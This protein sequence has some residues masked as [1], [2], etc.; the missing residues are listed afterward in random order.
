MIFLISVVAE[1]DGVDD[2]GLFYTSVAPLSTITM[3]SLVAD[4]G[5]VD[6]A[7]AALGVGRVDDE[8]AVDLT[9]AH[10]ADGAVERNVR[11]R[12]RCAGGV[13]ADDVGIVFLVSGEDQ[14]D[15]L[16]LVAEA[17]R[18]E[19]AD[20]AVDLAAGENFTLAG[21]AF[22]LDESAGD[23]AACIGVLAVVD[24]EGEEVDPFLGIRGGY[25]GCEHHAVTLRDQ[26]CAGGLLGHTASFKGQS[27]AT[28]KLN[29]HF[30]FH[31]VLVS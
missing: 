1:L 8:L 27:L 10:C 26:G 7:I 6:L 20:G 3:P 14:R 28:G 9:Y 15:D 11:E 4:D 24:G 31:I 23:A 18:E 19:R 2:N 22:A 30:V 29:C 5:D 13:D 17:F 12:Q 16:R 25:C 21:T